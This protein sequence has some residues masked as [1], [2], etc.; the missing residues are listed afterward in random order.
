[1]VNRPRRPDRPKW[2]PK[3]S[4]LSIWVNATT[5][6]WDDE[7]KYDIGTIVAVS[8]DSASINVTLAGIDAPISFAREA[9]SRGSANP[10][11]YLWR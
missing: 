5:V 4:R 8:A 7:N 10:R 2:R 1:M 9:A 3:T 11:L 6:R